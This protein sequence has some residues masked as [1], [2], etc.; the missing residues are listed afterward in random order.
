MV[1]TSVPTTTVCTESFPNSFVPAEYAMLG[2]VDKSE[3]IVCVAFDLITLQFAVFTRIQTRESVSRVGKQPTGR[4]RLS[5]LCLQVQSAFMIDLNQASLALRNA[6]ARS[7]IL[8]DEFG[9][10]RGSVD[11]DLEDGLG[12]RIVSGRLAILTQ[13]DGD[14]SSWVVSDDGARVSRDLDGS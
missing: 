13:N 11:V 1:L 6:T 9:N 2:V 10:L 14:G 8:L 12:R 7:L 5:K 4:H 3:G